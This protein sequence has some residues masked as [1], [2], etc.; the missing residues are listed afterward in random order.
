MMMMVMWMMIDDGGDG[1]GYSYIGISQGN[2]LIGEFSVEPGIY[3]KE[4]ILQINTDE[5]IK[6]FYFQVVGPQQEPQRGEAHRLD[7]QAGQGAQRAEEE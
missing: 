7:H 4:L 3:E 5:L 6:V 1:W 2:D